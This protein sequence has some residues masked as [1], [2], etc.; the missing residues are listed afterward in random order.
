[1]GFLALYLTLN[2]SKRGIGDFGIGLDNKKSQNPMKNKI[3]P[4]NNL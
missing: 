3:M 1:L 4:K 2:L